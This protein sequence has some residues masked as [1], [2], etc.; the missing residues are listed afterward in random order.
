M[1][2][3]RRVW[4]VGKIFL[5]VGA[6]AVTFLLFFGVSMRVALRAREV[7]VPSLV[8]RSVNEATQRLADL[9]LGLRI[10]EN[11]RPDERIPAGSIVQQDPAAGVQARQQRTVR[12]WVSS[13]PRTTIV[14]ILVGQT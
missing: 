4:G 1:P 8:G 2:L 9:G 12:V 6:L 11:Q 5:L 13:G 10:D 7:R 3:G 14:P